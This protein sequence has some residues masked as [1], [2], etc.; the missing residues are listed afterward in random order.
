MAAKKKQRYLVRI[1]VEQY[2]EA[3]S[4]QAA[5]AST[6]YDLTGD[7]GR[8]VAFKQCCICSMEVTPAGNIRKGP[9]AFRY[10]HIED[11]K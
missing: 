8:L 10:F 4:M 5:A 9:D 1:H 11:L 2:V 6:M 3:E 7:S